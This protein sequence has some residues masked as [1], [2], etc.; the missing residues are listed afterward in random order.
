MTI[1]QPQGELY[2]LTDIPLDAEYNNTMD[3]DDELSQQ[4]YFQSKIAVVFDSNDQNKGYKF[5]RDNQSINVYANIDDLFGCNYLMYKNKNKWYYAFITRKDYVSPEVTRLI[6]KLDVLQSFM[7]DYEINDSFIAREHQDRW[8]KLIGLPNRYKPIYNI[9]Q[10]NINIGN[11]YKV[12]EKIDIEEARSKRNNINEGTWLVIQATQP[13]DDSNQVSPSFLSKLQTQGNQFVQY[14]DSIPLGCYLYLLPLDYQSIGVINVDHSIMTKSV[15]SRSVLV[16]DTLQQD[17]R[18][19]N[20]F[21]VKGCPIMYFEYDTQDNTMY[22]D[23]AT[24]NICNYVPI[25]GN[26]SAVLIRARFFVLNDQRIILKKY[27]PIDWGTTTFNINNSPN[28]NLESK[29]LTHPYNFININFGDMNAVFKIEYFN[30]NPYLITEGSVG[31]NIQFFEF[32]N[33]Q[34]LNFD[35]GCSLIPYKYLNDD[36]NYNEKFD[37]QMIGQLPLKTD[38]WNEY[39]LNNQAS[40]NGAIITGILSTIASAG[41]GIATGG[42]GL[43]IAGGAVINTVTQIANEEMKREDIKNT[44]DRVRSQGQN[45]SITNTLIKMDYDITI[46]TIQDVYK[47]KVFNYFMHYGYACRDFKKPNT[48]SRYYYNYIQTI[49]CNLKSDIDN[50]Y[51]DEIKSI[52]DKGITIWHYRDANTFKGVGNYDYENAEMSLIL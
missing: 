10:E 18:I 39:L 12:E 16:L 1:I 40:K 49:G 3:F 23:N 29:L 36:Y 44:P 27:L 28:I 31:K 33:Y 20:M 43:A 25:S 6:I 9:E 7:F 42:V 8:E 30:N 17:S 11:A 48:K 51:R 37:T 13:I 4:T 2:I 46:L 21:I 19:Q 52:Y 24:C 34:S 45:Y 50:E 15:V 22:F 41:L 5:I 26:D 32:V 38:A 47:N 35:G 14:D